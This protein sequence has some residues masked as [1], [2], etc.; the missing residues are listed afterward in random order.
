MD[1]MKKSFVLLLTL[2]LLSLFAYLSINI[3]ETKSLQSKNLQNKYIYLQ[4]LNHNKFLKE[5]LQKLD[6]LDI[7]T[8]EIE[9]NN[10]HIRAKIF[11][12]NNKYRVET[13]VSSKAFDISI[14]DNFLK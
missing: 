2:S 3:L 8:I 6:L 9:D 4:A 14:A 7:K 12:I 10:F 5:Y 13:Y 1:F 11:K